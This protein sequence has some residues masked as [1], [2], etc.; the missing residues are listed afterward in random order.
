MT[1]N[2]A[3]WPGGLAYVVVFLA[4][5]I[6]GEVFFVAAAALAGQGVLN[7]FGVVA[8]GTLGA[9][10]GDQIPFYLLRFHVRAWLNRIP[11]V[12][13]VSGRLIGAVRRRRAL[14]PFLIR[15]APGLRIAISSACAYADVPPLIFSTCSVLGALVWATCIVVVVGWLGP[16]FLARLGINGWWGLAVPAVVFLILLKA[17]AWG[18]RHSVEEDP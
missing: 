5:L 9:A 15:F 13:R 17:I 16:E 4:A 6:E 7:P 14:L 12:Q 10:T 3:D 11:A 8:A 2:P 18:N 1:L